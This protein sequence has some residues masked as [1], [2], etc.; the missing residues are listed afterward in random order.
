MT[1]EIA[2]KFLD[3]NSPPHIVT[4][5]IITGLGAMVMN[6]F[7]PSLPTMTDYFDTEY[8]IVQLSVALYLGTVALLQMVVGPLSDR[9]GRRP[10]L[11]VGLAVFLLATIGCIYAPTIEIFLM[12]RMAQA[13]V[14]VT[15]VLSRAIARDLYDE[16]QAA[17]M[18]GY[19]TMG[20]AIIPMVTPA[21]GGVLDQ[22]F[23]WQATFW[24]FLILGAAVFWL[25]LAD[26]G[27]TNVSQST[28]FRQQVS[29]YPE[30]FLSPRFWGYCF[31][32][33]FASGA[34]FAYLGGAP[35]IGK[36]VY[37]MAPAR[38]GVFFGA[39]AL[40]YMVGNFLTGRYTVRVGVN[41][42]ILGGAILSTFGVSVSLTLALMGLGTVYTFFG[43]MIF[44]GLGNG[45]ILPNAISGMLSVRP[46]LAGTASGLGG[47]IMMGGGAALSALSGSLLGPGSGPFPL[48]WIMF[49]VSALSIVA[50]VLVITRE[51]VLGI[52]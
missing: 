41:R 47:A 26:V 2:P 31:A 8:R 50:I 43:F 34:F 33:A 16:A 21:I 22:A 40:G 17:S 7:L 23:G 11:L 18:I 3:K 28:S 35:F 29:Q 44:I 13:S 19:I 10:V 32:A 49:I 46:H 38:L 51:K 30:L 1:T 37:G 20:M 6:M 52:A 39:P 14:S 9:F 45:M 27:E 15:M 48:L 12:F 5:V 25:S 36:E 24:V 42:M 4:L